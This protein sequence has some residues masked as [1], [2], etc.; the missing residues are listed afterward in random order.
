MVTQTSCVSPVYPIH[1][2]IT[3]GFVPHCPCKLMNSKVSHGVYK[4]GLTTRSCNRTLL[5]LYPVYKERKDILKG[6]QISED[7]QTHGCILTNL[8]NV[9]EQLIFCHINNNLKAGFG[10]RNESSIFCYEIQDVCQ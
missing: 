8:D 6:K 5:T 10:K 9:M 4:L 3:M 7:F 2:V 1:L